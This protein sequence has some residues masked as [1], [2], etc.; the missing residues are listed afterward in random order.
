MPAH[1]EANRISQSSGAFAHKGERIN[2]NLVEENLL[3]H[4]KKWA[5]YVK[6]FGLLVI[7][8]HTID[9]AIAAAHI[10][11]TAVTAY[12]ATHGFSYQYI[13]EIDVFLKVAKEAGL[14]PQ[15]KY[16]SKFPD[17][18]LAT[19]SINLLSGK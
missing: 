6:K 9:P 4:F 3:E 16:F 2:N 10:G 13:V 8:L 5:P 11:R 1:L 7:E 14:F 19:V 15:E 18:N 12:D 17:S